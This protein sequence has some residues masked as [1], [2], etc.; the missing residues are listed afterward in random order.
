[1]SW[2]VLLRCLFGDKFIHWIPKSNST[3]TSMA[4]L[5]SSIK[6]TSYRFEV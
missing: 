3:F 4:S 2:Q 5:S 1:M 6:F